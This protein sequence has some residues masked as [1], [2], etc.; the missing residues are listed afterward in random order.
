MTKIIKQLSISKKWDEIFDIFGDNYNLSNY[1]F[2]LYV[3]TK[4]LYD[5][6]LIEGKKDVF[7][8]A[9]EGQFLQKLFDKFCDIK[10]KIDSKFIPIKSHYFYASRGSVLAA[11]LADIENEDFFYL[12]R[13]FKFMS[14]KE[15]MVSIGFS[16]EDI[17]NV[18]A[19]LNKNINRIAL[20][21]KSSR[22]F[23]SLKQN[24]I[25]KEIYEKR[26]LAQST[27]LKAYINSFNIDIKNDGMAFVD[28]GYHGT[29]Q[30]ILFKFLNKQVKI[31][32]YYLSSRVRSEENNTKRGLLSDLYNKNL[33]YPKIINYGAFKYELILKANHGRCL[34]Y[35]IEENNNP[36]PIL[37]T[38]HFDKE[39]FDDAVSGLQSQI[40]EKFKLIAYKDL[41]EKEDIYS[42]STIY[43]YKMIKNKS[44][45][46]WQLMDKLQHHHHDDFGI[47]GHS[48]NIFATKF[49]YFVFKSSDNSYLRKNLGKIKFIYKNYKETPDK[50]V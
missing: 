24:E 38:E 23:K 40:L 43:F 8:L 9:R 10:S 19:S 36:K 49:L 33:F 34:S 39:I 14:A 16:N 21:F 4:K 15:F 20:N 47:V 28:V 17:E 11:S 37:D 27:A 35:S 13:Y 41:T 50:K 3:F 12:F 46:D 7:F 45:Q 32:G 31:S 25:F 22:I 6:L 5:E 18:K 42:V 44:Q 30:D 26:R 29:M 1:A 2:P 48:Y